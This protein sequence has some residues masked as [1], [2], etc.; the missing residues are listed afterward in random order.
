MVSVITI[1]VLVNFVLRNI[2]ELRKYIDHNPN[3]GTVGQS[4]FD[5]N[6]MFLKLKDKH[7]T[8]SHCKFVNVLRRH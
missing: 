7:L 6:K 8:P 4:G 2:L 5:A 1:Q 3:Y